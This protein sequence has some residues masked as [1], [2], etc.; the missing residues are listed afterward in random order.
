MSDVGD[1]YNTY[2]II[3]SRDVCRSHSPPQAKTKIHNK[4]E[5]FNTKRSEPGTKVLKSIG[6][7][8]GPRVRIKNYIYWMVLV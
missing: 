7:R 6:K 8:R 2:D 3:P 1:I 5:K 4:N